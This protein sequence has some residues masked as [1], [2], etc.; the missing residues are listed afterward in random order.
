MNEE[1]GPPI[2]GLDSLITFLLYYNI[3]D[4]NMNCAYNNYNISDNNMICASE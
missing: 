4:N 1:R 2:G 3:S